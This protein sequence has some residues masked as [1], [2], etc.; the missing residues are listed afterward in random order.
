MTNCKWILNRC[1]PL[2]QL[3]YSASVMHRM[4]MLCTHSQENGH[5]AMG[6]FNGAIST[7]KLILGGNDPRLAESLYASAMVL[8][9]HCRYE[10]AMERYHDALRIQISTLGQSSSE[11]AIT[12]TSESF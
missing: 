5:K 11:V 8:S 7:R 12:L 2:L 1:I 6:F 3:V 10:S 9:Q 4:G